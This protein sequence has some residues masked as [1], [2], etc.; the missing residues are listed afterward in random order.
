MDLQTFFYDH[1]SVSENANMLYKTIPKQPHDYGAIT[2]LP[3]ELF[4]SYFLI[5][6]LPSCYFPT[7]SF[8]SY[9]Y[10]YFL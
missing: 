3:L 4:F 8:F 5:F 7:S 1:F 9:I 10:S 6:Q 2:D